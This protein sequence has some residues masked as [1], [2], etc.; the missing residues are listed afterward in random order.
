[1]SF[2]LVMT[3]D[4]AE[5]LD[6]DDECVWC[7]DDDDDLDYGPDTSETEILKHLAATD[8]I[9]SELDVAEIVDERGGAD[10][11]DDDDDDADE[12]DDPDDDDED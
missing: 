3:E 6:G 10:L 9:E 11:D 12:P 2:T 7:S 4:S 5:L 8:V 1:M